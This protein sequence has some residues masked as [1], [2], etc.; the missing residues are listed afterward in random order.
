MS[1]KKFV[2]VE[3]TVFKNCFE[4]IP[5]E[6]VFLLPKEDAYHFWEERVDSKATSYFNLSDDSWIITSEKEEL[7]MWIEAYNNDDNDS[8]S[9]LLQKAFCWEEN[10][11]IWFCV[12]KEIIFQSSWCI[13][14]KYWDCFIAAEDDCP[15]LLSSSELEEQA[16]LFRAIGDMHKINRINHNSK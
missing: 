14:L 2:S 6:K 16:L 7:G 15:I 13:F 4:G 10:K 9:D 12:S 5:P 3:K 8:V 1:E 11:P